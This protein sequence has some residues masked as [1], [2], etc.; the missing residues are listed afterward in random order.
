M[1]KMDFLTNDG[2][3]TGHPYA[4]ELSWTLTYYYIQKLTQ[5]VSKT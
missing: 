4:K 2:G 1:E 3:E 5:N